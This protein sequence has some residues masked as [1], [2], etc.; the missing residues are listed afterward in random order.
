MNQGLTRGVADGLGLAAA[1][2]FALMA[3]LT[4]LSGGPPMI[5]ALG[6]QPS[7]L[8][9]MTPMYLLMA[10]L[11]LGPWLRLVA[12]GARPDAGGSSP[13]PGSAA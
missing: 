12:G 4:A 5:C 3:G 9:G 8:A 13:R 1:P 10:A 2:A 6:P 11:H 7:W